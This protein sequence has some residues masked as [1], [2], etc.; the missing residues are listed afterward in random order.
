MSDTEKRSSDEKNAQLSFDLPGFAEGVGGRQTNTQPPP[1][2]GGYLDVCTGLGFEKNAP[3]KKSTDPRLHDLQK[4]GL[5]GAWLH[6]AEQ[7]G[8]DAF[9]RIWQLLDAE[10]SQ[11]GSTSL[12][13]AV[14]LRNY[15]TWIRY[16]RNQ[17]IRHLLLRG[18]T[19]LEVRMKLLEEL[20]ENV[21]RRHIYRLAKELKVQA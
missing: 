9:L 3:E 13:V 4:L 8:V 16:Q 1:A 17:R 18:Y 10:L 20:G 2:G 6:I 11:K 14:P 19:A 7:E 5:R 15:S 21:G 12:R